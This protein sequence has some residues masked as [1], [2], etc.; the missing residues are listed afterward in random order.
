VYTP[1]GSAQPDA[2]GRARIIAEGSA[3]A[4]P[5]EALLVT[6]EPGSGSSVPTGPVIVAWPKP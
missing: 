4:D 3:F 5:P 1:I 6:L 2:D